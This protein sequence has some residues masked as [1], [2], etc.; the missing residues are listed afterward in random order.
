MKKIKETF[1]FTCDEC[2][3]E[4]TVTPSTMPMARRSRIRAPR[5]WSR[6]RSYTDGVSRELH[7][8][9]DCTAKREH[10]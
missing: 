7:Y 6:W 5:G 9:A 10:R 8:C 2:G 3:K 1:F 4:V